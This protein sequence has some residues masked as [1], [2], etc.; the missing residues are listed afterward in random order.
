MAKVAADFDDVNSQLHTML[1]RLMNELSEL[2]SGWKG[3]GAVAFEN[4]KQQY[5]EDLKRLNTALAQTADSIRASG[6][7][8]DSTDTDAASRLSNSGG[9]VSLPL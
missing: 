9:T 6:T 1:S 4:V 5:A 3:L 2:N 7:S 8:Y